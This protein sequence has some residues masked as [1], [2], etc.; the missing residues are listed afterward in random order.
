MED[1][2]RV[3]RNETIVYLDGDLRQ[4]NSAA[5]ELLAAPILNGTADFVKGRFTRAAGRVTALTAQPLI[6]TYF[7]ELRGFAQPLGGII[8]ARRSLLRNLQFEND[9][10]VDAALLIDAFLSS[11]RIAEVDIG[12]IEHRSKPLES[13][14]EMATQVARAILDRAARAQ[15]LRRSFLRE[16]CEQ[17]RLQRLSL[18]DSLNQIAPGE[19][20]ALFDMD[21]VLLDGRFILG[22]AKATDREASLAALLDNYTISADQ[23]M[24]QIA[25]VFARVSRQTFEMAARHIPLMPGAVETVVGLRKQGYRVGIVTDSYYTAAEIV[26]RRV[27]ADFVFAHEMRFRNDRALGRV[28]LC[29]AMKHPNGCPVH[30]HC[31]V[32]VMFHL[33]ERFEL[34]RSSILAVGDG[35][36]DVCLLQS[37][38]KS[39]AFQPKS[40]NVR[41]A[42]KMEISDLH[43]LLGS[44]LS[45][46]D[47]TPELTAD[48]LN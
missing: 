31:K 45:H 37:A 18:D 26:R 39:F 11:A 27:F 42:A 17:E 34:S 25:S 12:L 10:G 8:A 30:S 46:R 40:L 16:T 29:P 44:D 14:S 21:G 33:M 19:K 9:Y 7:P 5:V 13:L 38:G 15:R 1:G 6:R 23:R 20:I 43:E 36:N 48:F 24:Q 32:N 22:L 41:N 2:L 4:L 3:A 35:E 28:A 47:G